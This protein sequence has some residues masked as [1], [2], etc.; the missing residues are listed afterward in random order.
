MKSLRTITIPSLP[1]SFKPLVVQFKVSAI[2]AFYFYNWSQN[3]PDKVCVSNQI[4]VLRGSLAKHSLFSFSPWVEI[5]LPIGASMPHFF[6][7]LLSTQ[8]RRNFS[9]W[10]YLFILVLRFFRLIYF[11]RISNGWLCLIPV[12]QTA[13]L[14]LHILLMVLRSF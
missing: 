2:P 7:R 10:I 5:T 13:F 4:R 1:H 3:F 14:L 12:T 11:A 6:Y 8:L 9:I